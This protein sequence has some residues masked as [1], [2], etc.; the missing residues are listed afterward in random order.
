MEKK[1][2]YEIGTMPPIGEVPKKMYAWTIRNERLGDPID[3]FKQEIVDVP[4]I[5]KGELLI[6]NKAAGVNYNGVWA[7]KGKPKNVITSNGDFDE[8]E[9][10]H[11]CGSEASGIVYAVGEGVKEFKVGDY[12]CAGGSQYDENCELIKSGVDPCFSPSYRIWGYEGNWGA[13]AQ[14]SKVRE[15]QCVKKPDFLSWE[16]SAVITATGVTV[17]R[18]LCRWKENKIKKRGCSIN[19]GRL[20]RYWNFCNTIS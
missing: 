11:I 14:F 15:C 16:E 20:W 9:D 10:F 1:E 12:V 6:F 3:A 7:A 17:Y 13:F 8:K 4:K 5:G 18:M 2:I 19:L